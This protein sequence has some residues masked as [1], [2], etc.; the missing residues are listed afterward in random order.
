VEQAFV[1][2]R[3]KVTEEQSKEACRLRIEGLKYAQIADKMG[4]SGPH[5][6]N[7]VWK[8]LEPERYEARQEKRRRKQL[9]R[10]VRQAGENRGGSP[11]QEKTSRSKQRA[12]EHNK[13]Y[14]RERR[15]TR[16]ALIHAI[17]SAPCADC[18]E[19]F[20]P[21]CMDFDHRPEELKEFNIGERYAIVNI[22]VLK[23]EIAKCDIVCANCHRIRTWRRDGL[24]RSRAK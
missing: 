1:D 10:K 22:D 6:Q 9:A 23:A 8:I 20:N 2:R 18:S 19:K 21:V 16:K 15:E 3:I 5:A 7:L 14:M 12:R 13:E 17:K 4:I 24:Y 11:R